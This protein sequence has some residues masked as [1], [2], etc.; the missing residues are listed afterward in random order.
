M[1][2]KLPKLPKRVGKMGSNRIQVEGMRA[3]HQVLEA[4]LPKLPK[5]MGR[6]GSNKVKI[7]DVRAAR[8]VLEAELPKLPKRVGRMVSNRM[9]V[10]GMRAARRGLEY[11][12]R[13]DIRKI[14][15][16]NARTPR[17]ML[18][19]KAEYRMR[20]LAT[21]KRHFGEKMEKPALR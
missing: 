5:C 14:R 6:T 11:M 16:E 18:E 12:Q 17:G 9:Q 2:A 1:E 21:E 4:E 13:A 15:A 8:R 10:E 20:M 19:A 7:R 3:P